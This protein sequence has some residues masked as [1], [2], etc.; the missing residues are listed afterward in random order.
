MRFA[1]SCRQMVDLNAYD[2]HTSITSASNKGFSKVCMLRVAI[3][4][5]CFPFNKTSLLVL[6]TNFIDLEANF[7]KKLKFELHIQEAAFVIHSRD[8]KYHISY[9]YGRNSIQ[10][11]AALSR[12]CRRVRCQVDNTSMICL[13]SCSINWKLR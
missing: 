11:K 3:I 7:L 2:H 13:T 6:F 1:I 10:V 5:F 12:K 4:K 9:S 8:E